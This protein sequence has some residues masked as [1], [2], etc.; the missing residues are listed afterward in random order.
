M[1]NLSAYLELAIYNWTANATAMPAA[2]ATVYLAL[3]TADPLD[4]GSG[5]AEVAGG[6][7]ARQAMSFGAGASVNGVGTTGSTNANIIFPTATAAW[8]IISHGAIYDAL[9]AGN[10]LWHFQWT[11]SKNIQIGD[12][13]T[14]ASGDFSLVVR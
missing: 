6:A 4:D 12:T 2:P 10:M 11:V 14:V 1:A 7:Y 5:M 3:S 13:Y 9:A 8:G